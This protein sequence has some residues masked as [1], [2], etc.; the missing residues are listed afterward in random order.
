MIATQPA[1]EGPGMAGLDSPPP[2]GQA[3][4]SIHTC[5][6]AALHVAKSCLQSLAARSRLKRNNAWRRRGNAA[7]A[8]R[9]R[10]LPP[11][12]ARV[13]IGGCR[14]R[15]RARASPSD[16]SAPGLPWLRH[17]PGT[18]GPE[19]SPPPARRR[20]PSSWRRRRRRWTGPAVGKRGGGVE[21]ERSARLDGGAREHASMDRPCS[22]EGRRAGGTFGIQSWRQR[23]RRWTGPA[24]DNDCMREQESKRRSRSAGFSVPVHDGVHQPA[25][26]A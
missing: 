5:L 23:R 2:C 26:R 9:A 25:S 6:R 18:P 15:R 24:V 13:P 21:V 20:W 7:Q 4:P 11:A 12:P 22:G 14:T 1:I 8:G 16:S 3:H 17:R 19:P 10:H